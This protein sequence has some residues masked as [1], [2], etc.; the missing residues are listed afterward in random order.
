MF[1]VAAKSQIITQNREAKVV[2]QDIESYEQDQETIALLK[3]LAL[4]EALNRLAES[5]FSCYR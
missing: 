1:R 5:G 3:M 4:D 2:L